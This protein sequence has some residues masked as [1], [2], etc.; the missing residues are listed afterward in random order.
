MVPEMTKQIS[1]LF[2]FKTENFYVFLHK[3]F[4]A[5]NCDLSKWDTADD[6]ENK[7]LK[8]CLQACNFKLL[9]N[10]HITSF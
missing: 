2:P 4:F 7:A 6:K 10:Q 8:R 9:Q 1:A 5:F 3:H